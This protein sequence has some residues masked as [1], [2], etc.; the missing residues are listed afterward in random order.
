MALTTMLT[1]ALGFSTCLIATANYIEIHAKT[2]EERFQILIQGTAE[3]LNN[4]TLGLILT[5]LACLLLA[6]G[7]R[8][9]PLRE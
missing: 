9:I 3:S 4:I 1:A 2:G 8:R 6:V 7:H 5:T